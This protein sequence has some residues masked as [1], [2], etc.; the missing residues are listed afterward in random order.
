MKIKKILQQL[1]L[2][3]LPL[4]ISIPFTMIVSNTFHLGAFSTSFDILVFFYSAILSFIV[5]VTIHELGH[6]IAF[7]FQGVQIKALFILV[8]GF[9]F[10]KSKRFVIDKTMLLFLGGIVIPNMFE[11]HSDESFYK[12]SNKFRISLL[13]APIVTYIWMFITIILVFIHTQLLMIYVMF[14]TI[15]FTVMFTRS[16]LIH[17]GMIIGDLK[18]FSH[19]K[20][21]PEY[22]LLILMQLGRQQGYDQKTA[23]YLYHKAETYLNQVSHIQ[24]RSD[25]LLLQYVCDGYRLGYL[26]KQEDIPKWLLKVSMKRRIPKAY[27][28]MLP[29]MVYALLLF[30]KVESACKLYTFYERHEDEALHIHMM[31]HYI[32]DIKM[33]DTAFEEYVD[34]HA[35]YKHTLALDF[36]KDELIKKA[37]DV[38]FACQI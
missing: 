19:L 33:T 21:H 11:I 16:F 22:V 29:T 31:N 15:T 30:Q 38:S 17:Q 1:G 37:N 14:W 23:L 7:I 36:V 18:A 10:G 28:M 25:Y 9:I 26:Q 27:M 8:L 5:A 35:M 2:F 4:M 20:K 3:I 12:T 34:M 32:F 6:V 24:K 13:T